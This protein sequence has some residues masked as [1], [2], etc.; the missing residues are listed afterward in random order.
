MCPMVNVLSNVR[1]FLAGSRG[2]TPFFCPICRK[3][4]HRFLPF[5]VE[6]RPNAQCPGCGSLER[7]RLLW[8][9]L[10][11]LGLIPAVA[12]RRLL[13]IAPEKCLATHF[14]RAF[15]YI[16][17][18]LEGSRAMMRMDITS[19]RFPDDHFD[20]V[21]CNHVLEHVADDRAALAELWRVLKP[22]GW[23]SIQV[24]MTGETTLEDPSVTEPLERERRFG[25]HDHVRSYGVDFRCRLEQV[26]FD[27]TILPKN[28]LADRELLDRISVACEDAVWLS[29]LPAVGREESTN[30]RGFV[31]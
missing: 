20:A 15:E 14:R 1:N 3:R 25:Q 19:L 6:P 5:G 22:G 27:V 24:P 17:V 18:D 2:A 28:E 13:H 21:V 10:E 11:S 23:A 26:G 9:A 30:R 12:G 4:F 16:S 8:L 29:V 31:S 7:H